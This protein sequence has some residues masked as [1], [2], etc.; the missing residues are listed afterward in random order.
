MENTENTVTLMRHSGTEED[1]EEQQAQG[2]V[3]EHAQKADNKHGEDN[4]STMSRGQYKWLSKLIESIEE[5]NAQKMGKLLR[6]EKT[7]KLDF[8]TSLA[9]K[10]PILCRLPG[11]RMTL[12]KLYLLFYYSH[13]RWANLT[14]FKSF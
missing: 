4:L 5:D 11:L 10:M 3:E 6:D 8:I 12:R 9:K 14:L 2:R 13:Q 7:S 1:A